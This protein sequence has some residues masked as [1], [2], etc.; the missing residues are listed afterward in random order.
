[1][2]GGISRTAIKNIKGIGEFW[3]EGRYAANGSLHVCPP[4]PPALFGRTC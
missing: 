4:G 2:S 3:D 1:V